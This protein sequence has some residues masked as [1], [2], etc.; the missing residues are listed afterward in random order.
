MNSNIT[1][2]RFVAAFLFFIYTIVVK[3]LDGEAAD[4]LLAIG[5]IISL[6]CFALVVYEVVTSHHIDRKQKAWWLAGLFLTFWAGMLYYV[7]A[8]R[9]RVKNHPHGM[10]TSGRRL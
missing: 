7:F 5:L 1:K 9:S 10:P 8:G 3:Y 6:S 4:T 2:I